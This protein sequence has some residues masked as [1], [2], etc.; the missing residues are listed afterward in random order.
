MSITTVDYLD[1][2]LIAG[3]VVTREGAPL[4]EDTYYRGM[5][6]AFDGSTYVYT[7]TLPEAIY[8]GPTR[9]LS[10]SGV[11][12]IITGGQVDSRGIVDDSGDALTVT[13]AMIDCAKQYG[14][15]IKL[16]GD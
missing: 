4:G 12:A 13:E 9:T 6:L 1:D 8:N 16:K 10:G 5:P 11:G 15:F 2:K 7:A 14:L 3:P